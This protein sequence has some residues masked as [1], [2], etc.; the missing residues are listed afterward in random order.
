MIMRCI[1]ANGKYS[2][3]KYF[4]YNIGQCQ[5]VLRIR[6]KKYEITGIESRDTG[7]SIRSLCTD[8]FVTNDPDF[9]FFTETINRYN[10]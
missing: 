5:N 6:I 3:K 1:H 9:N 2:K 8:K 10:E 4:R 7:R